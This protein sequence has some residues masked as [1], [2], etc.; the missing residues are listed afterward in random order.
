MDL[1]RA[2]NLGLRFLL[3]LA[4]LA[5]L[6]WWGYRTGE[7]SLAKLGLAVGLPLVAGAVWG[8]FVAPKAALPVPGPVRLLLQIA[9][10]GAATAALVGLGHRTPAVLFGLVAVANAALMAVW[11]Q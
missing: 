1:I 9:I 10:F 4:A 11:D 3:E 2:L 6:G 8:L 7:G 5:I